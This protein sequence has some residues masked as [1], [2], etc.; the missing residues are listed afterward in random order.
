MGKTRDLFKKIRDTKG[1]FHAKMGTIKDRNGM[2]LTEAED[3]KKRWQEYTEELYK[4]GLDDP[5]NCNG[6]ITHLEPD[7][8]DCEVKWALGSTTINKASG[9][10]GI[11]AEL[12]EI[13]KGDAVKVL[14][15]ICL[16]AGHRT[17]KSQFSFQSQ[18]RAMP[19]NV[20]STTQLHSFHMLAR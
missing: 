5:D 9:G 14:L 11:P 12:L 8:L 13:L 3:I 18:R 1:T 19:Q 15:S 7:I 10:D 6:V 16:S 4:E 20:Q 2:D 17:G